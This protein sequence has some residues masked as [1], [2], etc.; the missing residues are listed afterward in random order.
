MPTSKIKNPLK[1]GLSWPLLL[2]LAALPYGLLP[3]QRSAAQP[4]APAAAAAKPDEEPPP[5]PEP[6]TVT[7][8]D[9]VRG[10]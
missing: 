2:L 3:G 5:E 1:N 8:T 9:G 10:A 7:T 4:P 6:F